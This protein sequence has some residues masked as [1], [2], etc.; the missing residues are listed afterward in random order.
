LKERK[1]RLRERILIFLEIFR[2]VRLTGG[3]DPVD[4]HMSSKM[5]QC[6]CGFMIQSPSENEIVKMTQMHAMDTHRQKMTSG[7]VMKMMKPAMMMR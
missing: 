7:D 4:K 3:R 1:E 6:D 2:A 5:V